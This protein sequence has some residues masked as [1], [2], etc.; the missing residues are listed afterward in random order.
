MERGAGFKTIRVVLVLASALAIAILLITMR[1]RA[2]RKVPV[3]KGILVQVRPAKAVSTHMIIESHGTV[4][5]REELKLLAEVQG[6]VVAIHSA[7][8]E[9]RP[10]RIGTKMITIDPRNY[11]LEVKRQQVQIEQIKAEL[12]HLKQQERNLKAS[13]AI[14]VSNVELARAELERVR[15]LIGKNV[16]AQTTA[17]KTEQRYLASLEKLQRLENELALTG[18]SRQSLAA[19]RE[20]AEVLWQQAQL[21]LEKTVIIALF[22]GWVSE[23]N[24]EIGQHVSVGQYLGRIYKDGA[25]DIEVR[26]PSQDLQWLDG[27]KKSGR[28]WA[29]EV[30]LDDGQRPLTW[31]GK[32][33]RSKAL[34]DSMTRTQPFIVEVDKPTLKQAARTPNPVDANRFKPGL[35]VKIKIKGRE[36]PNIYILPRHLIRSGDVVYT[37][38]EDRLRI[39]PVRIIR[40]FKDNVF[41]DNGIDEGDLIV[42][43]PLSGAME[44]MRVRIKP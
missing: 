13:I 11:Q 7:F 18:P 2:E 21:N 23:K 28:G 24:I 20:M 31:Q 42:Q 15:K 39:K 25:Y 43:T 8:K 38:R 32:V 41:I 30:C 29:A 1:P 34:I 5:P 22:D 10:V 36:L 16:V 3:E 14:A 40:Y 17:D 6:Q 4:S 37:V 35:F 26:L 9:G 12:Q 27:D 44:G 19:Q 33:T